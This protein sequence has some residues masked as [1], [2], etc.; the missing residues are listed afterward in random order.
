MT[1]P[2]SGFFRFN[3]SGRLRA[4]ASESSRRFEAA[5][6]APD[7][8]GPSPLLRVTP[9]PPVVRA[10]RLT[11]HRIG[12]VWGRSLLLS[13]VGT[14]PACTV[15]GSVSA[16]ALPSPCAAWGRLIRSPAPWGPRDFARRRNSFAF[17]PVCWGNLGS[18]SR[19]G[20]VCRSKTAVCQPNNG[21]PESVHGSQTFFNQQSNF[22]KE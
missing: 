5:R 9:R 15:T 18:A 14:R 4:L 21:S 11:K 7:S 1:L 17:A 6:S 19:P 3:P 16:R 20:C 12:R 2:V 8:G 10:S 22:I 13:L